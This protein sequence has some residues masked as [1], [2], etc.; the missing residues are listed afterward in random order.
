MLGPLIV[1]ESQSNQSLGR[2]PP[3][4]ARNHHQKLYYHPLEHPAST[5]VHPPWIYDPFRGSEHYVLWKTRSRMGFPLAP[6]LASSICSSFFRPPGC[7]FK[8]A[9][10]STTQPSTTAQ[11]VPSK[12]RPLCSWTSAAVINRGCLLTLDSIVGDS[13]FRLSSAWSSDTTAILASKFKEVRNNG[14]SCK[15]W[16]WSWAP[17]WVR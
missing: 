1:Q 10:A 8:K 4:H 9:V 11:K 5:A 17:V 6:I 3:L 16:H 12:S 13:M 7:V 15:Q 2:I 14:L